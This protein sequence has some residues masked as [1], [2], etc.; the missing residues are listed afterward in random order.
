VL[1]LVNRTLGTKCG[2][3]SEYA[4]SQLVSAT[5]EDRDPTVLLYE[6]TVMRAVALE[7]VNSTYEYD[8][9]DVQEWRS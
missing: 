9:C 6:A 5:Q 3:F 2:L 4:Y 1:L 7:T 8:I